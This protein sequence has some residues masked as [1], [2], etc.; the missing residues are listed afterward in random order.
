[1]QTNF[2]AKIHTMCKQYRYYKLSYD[3]LQAAPLTGLN[4]VM[5]HSHKSLNIE[6]PSDRDKNYKYIQVAQTIIF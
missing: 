4:A 1:M 5:W 2:D 6:Q 3:Q